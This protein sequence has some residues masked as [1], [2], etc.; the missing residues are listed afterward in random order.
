MLMYL[1]YVSMKLDFKHR[2][3]FNSSPPPKEFPGVRLVV[4][5]LPEEI[6]PVSHLRPI[7]VKIGR[8]F[9]GKV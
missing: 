7:K 8:S 6:T 4:V 3:E 5:H 1:F 9:V 2:A